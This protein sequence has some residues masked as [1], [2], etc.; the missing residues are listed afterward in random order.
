M[1]KDS[2]NDHKRIAKQHASLFKHQCDISAPDPWCL[3][4]LGGASFKLKVIIETSV[5]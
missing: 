5:F 1:W 2:R 4:T 3:V